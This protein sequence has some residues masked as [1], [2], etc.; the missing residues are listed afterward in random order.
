V[1]VHDF[2]GTQT[3]S[4]GTFTVVMPTADANNAILRIA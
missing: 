1:S 2:G 3:V 4:N